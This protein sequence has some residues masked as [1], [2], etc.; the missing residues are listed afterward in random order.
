MRLIFKRVEI[1]NFMSFADEVF[2]FDKHIGLN[3][4]CGKNNDIPGSKNG[5][6]KSN[7]IRALCFALYGDPGN[8]LK[9]GNI[10]NK[11]VEGK[12]MRV[13]AFF[14]V[15]NI[16]YRIS[17]GFNK[18]GAPYCELVEIDKESENG[19]ID[20][21]KS[22]IM[23]TRKYLAKE[24]LHC[25]ID[26]FLR[27]ILLSS[28][29]TYNFFRLSRGEKKVF[30]EKLFDISVFGNIYNSI[31]HEVLQKDKTILSLQNKLLV[32][33]KNND[34]YKTHIERHKTEIQQKISE[35]DTKLK[36]LED[37]QNEL[38]SQH[39]SVNSAE[40]K[41]YETAID[42][43]NV[44]IRQ[45]DKQHNTLVKANQKMEIEIHKLQTSRTQKQK[46]I[47]KH[48]ELLGK[49]CNDCKQIF[50]D[51]YNIGI[52]KNDIETADKD[53]SLKQSIYSK[54]E[55][56]VKSISDKIDLYKTKIEKA[57]QKIRDLTVEFNKANALLAKVE[58]NIVQVQNDINKTKNQKNPYEELYQNNKTEM[59]NNEKLLNDMSDEYKHLKFAENIVSQ[60]TLR[61]FIIGD[62][63]GLLNNKIKSYLTK[64]GAKYDVKFDADMNYEFITS[65]GTYEYDNF[66]AGERMRLMIASCFAFRDFMYIRNNLS[67]NILMLDEFIDGNVDSIAIESILSILKDFSKMWNQNVFVISH[68][69]EISNDIFDN[70]IQVVKTNN[71]S[72]VTY[73]QD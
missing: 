4:I 38:K 58:A 28:D 14:N 7:L 64:F 39:I 63:V 23:E 26:I 34:E 1:H 56:D 54:N 31:H 18:H 9:N 60:E 71:I 32:L 41:K 70:I 49:L 33:N 12:E 72:E 61:K 10:A 37:K 16:E 6:G 53:I 51:Y 68:R 40:V 65:A 20:L 8:G 44:A 2:D 48:A 45:L 19:E 46:L 35:L 29:Q 21:A 57:T 15:D 30:I 67:C 3:L 5:S 69:R 62:L 27:T 22:T 25:D 66:S 17:S 13:T 59:E 42:K 43:I 52:Y 24:I 11:F 73:I 55:A 36:Q 50:S 47:D